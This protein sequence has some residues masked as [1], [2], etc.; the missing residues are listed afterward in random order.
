MPKVAGVCDV[1][2]ST[3][4]S[5]RVDDNEKTVRDRLGI[6]Y[7]QTAPLVSYY[8]NHGALKTIDG[9]A[10]IGD[11]TRQIERVLNAV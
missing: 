8:G 11:V 6:Y 2:G 9:M 10:E 4:F 5:R 1:C 3:A 7:K